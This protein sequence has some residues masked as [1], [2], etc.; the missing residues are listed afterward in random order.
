MSLVEQFDAPLH[1][2]HRVYSGAAAGYGGG[3]PRVDR[4]DGYGGGT[5][6]G[7]RGGGVPGSILALAKPSPG[8]VP[9]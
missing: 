2:G 5:R 6:L 8:P 3:V 9:A 7:I 4:G 1:T